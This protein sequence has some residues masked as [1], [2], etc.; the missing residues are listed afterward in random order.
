MAA[1]TG[2]LMSDYSVKHMGPFLM[3]TNDLNMACET[4]VSMG[5]Y[6]MSFERVT[7]APNQA[8]ISSLVTAAACAEEVVWAQELRHIR[9]IRSQDSAEAT[10]ARIAQRR[11]HQMVASRAW[12]AWNR[13][14]AHY[15]EPGERCPDF[16]SDED[17]VVYLLG[18]IAGAQAVQHDRATGG[19]VGVPLDVPRKVGRAAKCLNN[20]DWWGVPRALQAAIWTGVP[21]ATPK[22]EDPWKRL[23]ESSAIGAVAGV[24]LAHAIYAQTAAAMGKMEDVRKIIVEHADSLKRKEPAAR[25]R[26]LDLTAT[27]QIEALSDRIW[28][29]AVG[30][31]TPYGQ[32]GTFPDDPVEEDEGGEDMLDD[33]DAEEPAPKSA[34]DVTSQEESK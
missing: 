1:M 31:R 32:L 8:A 5:A 9:A 15:G 30:H 2:D 20:E 22:G 10:D 33:L 16:E 34:S 28:T 25:W 27:R 24:R 18:L 29:E 7:D 13:L 19:E 3:T 26:L 21:G 12:R 17:Q 6:L 23:Q 11:A 14:V 4:G